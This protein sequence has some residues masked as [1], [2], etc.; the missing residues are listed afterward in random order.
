MSGSSVI[1]AVNALPVPVPGAPAGA[2]LAIL[3]PVAAGGVDAGW[4]GKGR[5]MKHRYRS[6]KRQD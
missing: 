2:T 3:N 6:L 5:A 4:S 1:V